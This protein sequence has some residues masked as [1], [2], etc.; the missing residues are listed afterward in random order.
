[1]KTDK[2]IQRIRRRNDSFGMNTMSL[3]S[4]WTT[5]QQAIPSKFFE[6]FLKL[7]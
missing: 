1:M 7:I 2:H 3:G 6:R 5:G 4:A